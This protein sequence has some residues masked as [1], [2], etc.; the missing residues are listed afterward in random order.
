MYPS[1]MVRTAPPVSV[2]VRVRVSFSLR[3]LFCIVRIL[4]IAD[5]NRFGVSI[6][7]GVRDTSCYDALHSS[8]PFPFFEYK[9][10]NSRA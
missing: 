4:A 6:T 9:I 3:I 8:F 1:F 2:R 7:K 10:E 5:L